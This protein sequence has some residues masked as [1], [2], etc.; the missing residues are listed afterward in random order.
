V[1]NIDITNPDE[2]KGR[3]LRDLAGKYPGY[4]TGWEMRDERDGVIRDA[5][6]KLAQRYREAVTRR[7]VNDVSGELLELKGRYSIETDRENRRGGAGRHG[8]ARGEGLCREGPR[9]ADR[10]EDREIGTLY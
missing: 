3:S 8:G 7:E 6:L 4:E 1:K 2:L 9:G 5:A 10:P